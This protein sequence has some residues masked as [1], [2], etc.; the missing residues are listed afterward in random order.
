MKWTWLFLIVMLA[1]CSWGGR[2]DGLSDCPGEVLVVDDSAGIVAAMLS[3]PYLALTDSEPEFDVISKQSS[4]L[5]S[6]DRYRPL[7]VRTDIGQKWKRT[8]VA[9]TNNMYAREQTVVTLRA[10]SY[11]RL[12][13]DLSPQRLA[14][15]LNGQI[16]RREANK[17]RTEQK[18]HL[19]RNVKREFNL[20]IALPPIITL[21]KQG[22]DFLWLSS[23]DGEFT[24][25]F[26]F[27]RS[28]NRDSVMQQNIKGQTDRQ[29][30]T[31][32]ANSV[33][34]RQRHI[35]SVALTERRGLWRMEGDAMGGCYL[36]YAF[37]NPNDGRPIVAEAFVYAPQRKKRDLIRL[38]EASLQTM[39]QADD[40]N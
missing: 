39:F 20:D 38:A 36:Q 17:L 28:E 7:I 22:Q 26:C 13:R 4:K 37:L 6:L 10:S 33:L 12:R 35:G 5:Q 21:A 24:L 16:I 25:N 15:L 27:Y 9:Y 18:N 8:A 34:S 14:S 40:S 11:D 1:S 30:M 31:T 3:R 23:A 29:Y 32:V 2:R 19:A